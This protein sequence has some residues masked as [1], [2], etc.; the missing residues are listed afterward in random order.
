V[1][2]HLINCNI[3][4]RIGKGRTY[5][6]YPAS[7]HH[8]TYTQW[9]GHTQNPI[10][11]ISDN[12]TANV[13]FHSNMKKLHIKNNGHAIKLVMWYNHEWSWYNFLFMGGLFIIKKIIPEYILKGHLITQSLFVHWSWVLRGCGFSQSW[14]SFDITNNERKNNLNIEKHLDSSAIF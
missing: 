12:V 2:H 4:G 1:E 7:Q 5:V 13:F 14:K 8:N 9:L 6:Q 10:T 3:S 11:L